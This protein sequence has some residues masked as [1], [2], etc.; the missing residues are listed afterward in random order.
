MK[1]TQ[2][3]WELIQVLSMM[4]FCCQGVSITW[5]LKKNRT[6]NNLWK[7]WQSV[8]WSIT[9]LITLCIFHI[10]CWILLCLSTTSFHW[11]FKR[12]LPV[13]SDKCL[14]FVIKPQSAIITH[15]HQTLVTDVW[16][17]HRVAG[18]FSTQCLTTVPTVMLFI[19][20]ATEFHSKI[21]QSN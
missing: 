3:F 8:W 19:Q 18:T 12:K 6:C 15:A 20:S 13:N 17:R 5:N 4:L 9:N 7:L 14:L 1:H 10:T 11:W 21:Q 16:Y 2:D